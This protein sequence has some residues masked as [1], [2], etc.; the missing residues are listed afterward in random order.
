[1][2]RILT[3]LALA[4]FIAPAVVLVTPPLAFAAWMDK[5]GGS[6]GRDI[7]VPG[8]RYYH[9]ITADDQDTSD[10]DCTA[11]SST[12]KLF[13]PND[14]SASLTYSTVD[15]PGSYVL[16]SG[17]V[18]TAYDYLRVYGQVFK[19]NVDGWTTGTWYVE[20]YCAK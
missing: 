3:I 12:S 4:V 1:M 8:E 13:N 15:G 14:A 19:V 9:T 2:K 18:T 20:Y 11:C 6:V 17:T 16:A 5:D 7:A 10:M